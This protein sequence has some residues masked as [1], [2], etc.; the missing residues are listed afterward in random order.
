MALTNYLMHSLICTTLFYGYGFGLYGRV[1]PLAG[2]LISSAVFAFQMLFSSW[3]L[4]RFPYGPMEWLWRMWT[5]DGLSL[6]RS[7]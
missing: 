5:Y 7:S 4:R 2:L 3:W 1:G 6:K